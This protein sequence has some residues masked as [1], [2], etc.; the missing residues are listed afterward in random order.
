VL[1]AALGVLGAVAARVAALLSR[2]AVAAAPVRRRRP[3]RVAVAVLVAAL[4][5]AAIWG[6]VLRLP[7]VHELLIGSD[8][9]VLFLRVHLARLLTVG[10]GDLVHAALLVALAVLAARVPA[11]GRRP[12]LLAAAVSA[13][14]LV[15]P[16]AAALPVIAV[17]AGAEAPGVAGLRLV[18]WSG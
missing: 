18:A 9:E 5:L 15:L 3:A 10:P 8:A 14:M 6:L 17:V 11:P 2:G 13:A 7:P 4:V 1:G 16:Y 12:A